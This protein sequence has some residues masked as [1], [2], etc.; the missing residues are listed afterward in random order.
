MHTAA[1][2]SPNVE[3]ILRWIEWGLLFNCLVDNLLRN[4][5]PYLSGAYWRIGLCLIALGAFS[6]I[7][8]PTHS[9]LPRRRAYIMAGFSLLLIVQAAQFRHSL[10]LELFTIKA[11][12]LLSRREAIVT[13]VVATAAS[14]S[15]SLWTL[16]V[17]LEI[18]QDIGF[19]PYFENPQKLVINSLASTTTVT[20][21]VLFFGFMF[22]AEQRSRHRAQQLSREVEALATKLERS[23][24]ARDIHDSLGHSLTT[25]DVQLA[26]AERYHQEG[27]QT[28]LQQAIKTSQQLATQC[29][30]EARQSLRTMRES[31]FDL[32]GSLHTLSEQMRLSLLVKLQIRLPSLPQ[33]LSYQ[34]YLIAKEGLVNVQKHAQATQATLSIVQVEKTIVMKLTDDGCGFDVDKTATGYGLK[35]IRERSQLLGGQ[36]I[37][38]S[39][40]GQGTQLQLTVPLG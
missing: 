27:A 20:L 2:V 19:A 30:A 11:C 40:P 36:L 39:Q 10:L 26:L 17:A 38:E 37:V 14:Y 15:Y 9:S 33:Q 12:L 24:I 6:V 25:L 34:L 22:V 31:S 1:P 8:L 5:L 23:R 29:L 28:K 4:D 35:G 32:A 18:A 7:R 13:T 3:K 16:P 21:F